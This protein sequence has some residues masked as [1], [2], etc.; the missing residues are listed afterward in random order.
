MGKH[1]FNLGLYSQSVEW[2]GQAYTL[3]GLERNQT[4]TQEQV[5][6]FLNTAIKMVKIFTF[7]AC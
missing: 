5:M 4:I 3:A 1:S 7:I 2:F 6:Q